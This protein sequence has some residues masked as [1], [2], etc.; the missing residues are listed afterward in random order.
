MSCFQLFLQN[1]SAFARAFARTRIGAGTLATHGQT[2]A[3]TETTVATNVHQALDVHGGLAAE[4]TF[5]REQT[6]LIADLFKIAVGEVLDLLGISNV[7]GFADFASARATNAKNRS[8]AD[9]G[10][11]M[12]RN[13]DTSDTSHM[14]P[15]NSLEINLDAACGADQC[16]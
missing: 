3:M 5:D 13:V 15:L 11:L 8:Q 7:A 1:R 10:V 2:A 4:V 14:R 9:F 12:R 6:D 16:K